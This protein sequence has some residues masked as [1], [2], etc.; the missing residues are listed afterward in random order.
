MLL[1]FPS[2]LP[3]VL[4]SAS[5]S[6]DDVPPTADAASS[7]RSQAASAA[8]PSLPPQAPDPV[9]PMTPASLFDPDDASSLSRSCSGDERS[10]GASPAATDALLSQL[11]GEEAQKIFQ[12][13][14]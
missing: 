12:P 5:S 4:R 10:K 7:T 8:L 14:L 9:D 2:R 11:F 1:H 13:F 3:R 6:A